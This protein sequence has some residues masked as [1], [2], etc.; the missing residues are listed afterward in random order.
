M[1]GGGGGGGG[2]NHLALLFC[3]SVYIFVLVFFFQFTEAFLGSTLPIFAYFLLY[4]MRISSKSQT[5]F[6]ARNFRLVSVCLGLLF[7]NC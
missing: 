4:I 1:N 7:D 6:W 2:L 3:K 5:V